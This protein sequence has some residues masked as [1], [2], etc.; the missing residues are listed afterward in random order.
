MDTSPTVY[1]TENRNCQL[2]NS[3]AS[4]PPPAPGHLTDLQVLVKL[5]ELGVHFVRFS[6]TKIPF[7]LRHRSWALSLGAVLRTHNDPRL[8]L[9][10]IPASVGATVVDVDA[11]DWL[12]LVQEFPPA[13]HNQSRTVGRRHLT[14]RDTSARADVNGWEAQECRGDLR[15][16]GPIVLYDAR[17]LLSA[18]KIGLRGVRF[19]S[20]IFRA[21]P[22][23][24]GKR[25]PGAETQQGQDAAEGHPLPSSH[26]PWGGDIG[27][28]FTQVPPTSLESSQASS[29][30]CELFDRLREWAYAHVAD[31]GS[32]EGWEEAVQSHGTAL[33]TTVLDPEQYSTA[34]VRATAR[35]VAGWTW[36]RR[37]SFTGGGYWDRGPASQAWRARLRA[38]RVWAKNASRDA[39]IVRLAAAG[40]SQRVVARSVGVS[41]S[42][43]NRVLHRLEEAEDGAL[44]LRVNVP[45]PVAEYQ[46]PEPEELEAGADAI[47]PETL[48][49]AGK[50]TGTVTELRG[51]N[52]GAKG[53]PGDRRPQ[54]GVD[55]H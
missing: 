30:P 16:S 2:A 15:G 5:H 36:E 52:R 55:D 50:Q 6:Q 27:N 18:L 7:D 13:F 42:T 3:P 20:K 19:P 17:T 10:W 14:Y 26:S 31:A 25:G 46:E 48:D 1:T 21:Q 24:V 41:Q 43:V 34:R 39:E 45:E 54:G 51:K 28:R 11:G 9:G 47:H 49:A 53:R 37:D 40:F 38:E 32:A 33:V 4:P 44:E 29:Q 23:Q 22:Q 12:P 35:S 8:L